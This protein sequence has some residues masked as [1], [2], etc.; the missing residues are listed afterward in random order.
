MFFHVVHLGSNVADAEIGTFTSRFSAERL[1][2]LQAERAAAWASAPP[3]TTLVRLSRED[4]YLSEG[5]E[6]VQARNELWT[7]GDVRGAW[8]ENRILEKYYGPVLD[9][10]THA[11]PGHRWEAVQRHDAEQR[12][13]GQ[14]GFVS[15]AYPYRIYAWPP[16]GFWTAVCVLIVAIRVAGR[17]LAGA[18]DTHQLHAD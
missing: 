5:L 15:D 3:P 18:T 13:G 7:A 1:L 16:L 8:F 11:G 2:A 12:G 4:Q 6:H 14:G 9:T 17:T 10:P